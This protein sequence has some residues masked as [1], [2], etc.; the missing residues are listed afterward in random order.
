MVHKRAYDDARV[1]VDTE[2][3]L[4]GALPS[5]VVQRLSRDA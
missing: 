2:V 3:G 1:P 5:R 4:G